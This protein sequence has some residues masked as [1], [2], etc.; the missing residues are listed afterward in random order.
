MNDVASN[1]TIVGVGTSG[2]I[3]GGGLDIDEVSNVIIQ[4]IRFSGSGDDAINMQDESE[5]VWVDHCEFGSC[6]DGQV[7]IKRG[8]N[9]VTV[10]WCHFS[11]HDHCCLLGHSDNNGD[12]DRGRG[13]SDHAGR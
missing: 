10:S 5:R 11:D 13:T 2:R 4:N 3:T 7:D 9:N 12:Q 1:K 6:S 8:T